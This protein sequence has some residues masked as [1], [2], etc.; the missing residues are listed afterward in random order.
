MITKHCLT[1]E[2]GCCPKE[3]GS[4]KIFYTEP[5]LLDDGKHTFELQ[6]DCRQC[7]MIIK[8]HT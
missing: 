6:F 1:F 2:L 8:M 5:L 7:V 3:K 4:K